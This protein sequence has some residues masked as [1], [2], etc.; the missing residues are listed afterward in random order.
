[1][2]ARPSRPVPGG[3]LA[4]LAVALLL[5]GA[6]H[7]GGRLEANDGPVGSY[8]PDR[9]R[10]VGS[11]AGSPPASAKGLTR[12]SSAAAAAASLPLTGFEQRGGSSWTTL[13]EEQQFLDA[14]DGASDRISVRVRDRTPQD[15]PIRLVVA[16]PPLTDAEIEANGAILFVCAQHGNEPAGREACLQLARDHAASP[17]TA[18]LL[19]LPTV[20]PDGVAAGTRTNAAG[21][22]INR[23]HVRLETREARAVARVLLDFRPPLVSDMHEYPTE[24]VRSVLL[25]RT[26]TFFPS[27][28][29]AIVRQVSDAN[30]LYLIPD[31]TAAGFRAGYYKDIASQAPSPNTLTRMSPLRHATAVLVETPRLGVLSPS[32]RVQAQ[33]TTGY[34]LQRMWNAR[35]STLRS[36][37]EDSA[38]RAEEAGAA[39]SRY[40]FT[41][42]IHADAPPCGYRL[43]AAQYDTLRWRFRLQGVEVSAANGGWT[44]PMAQRAWPLA[45][46]LLDPRAAEE[47]TTGQPLPCP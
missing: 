34:A 5:A 26:S 13:A 10:E 23:D 46:L 31:L 8:A 6:V 42:E 44:V 2:T 32:Q 22:D 38:R 43:S 12:R 4:V 35:R 40:H 29:A 9:I 21:A 24:G 27:T 15:R 25:K 19:V 11:P 1:M 18:T 39:G 20:N 30:E 33:L 28:D 36:T 14:L 45:G 7:G 17:S 3:G 16:G 41:D 37:S 47:L